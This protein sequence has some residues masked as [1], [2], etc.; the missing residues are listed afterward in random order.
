MF[1]EENMDLIKAV[2]AF[3]HDFNSNNTEYIIVNIPHNMGETLRLLNR[4]RAKY[5]KDSEVVIKNKNTYPI[6][7]YYLNIFTSI[8]DIFN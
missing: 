5:Y 1:E 2:D 8:D 6:V 3:S 7:V 4:H